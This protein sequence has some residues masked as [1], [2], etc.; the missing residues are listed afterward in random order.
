Q[1]STTPA[2]PSSTL[3]RLTAGR[4]ATDPGDEGRPPGLLSVESIV[5]PPLNTPCQLR[6][7]T[8]AALMGEFLQISVENGR[9]I[10]FHDPSLPDFRAQGSKKT[11]RT[12]IPA[13]RSRCVGLTNDNRP[14]ATRRRPYAE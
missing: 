10:P 7:D 2:N 11:R 6:A 8:R 1:I 14:L 9:G 5:L 3:R 4:A 13:Q 12:L